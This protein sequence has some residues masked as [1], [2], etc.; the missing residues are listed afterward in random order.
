MQSAFWSWRSRL[1]GLISIA[2][3]EV[4]CSSSS[5]PMKRMAGRGTSK[6]TRIQFWQEPE[7]VAMGFNAP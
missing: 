5:P 7:P 1:K 3:P 6:D 2:P 4:T